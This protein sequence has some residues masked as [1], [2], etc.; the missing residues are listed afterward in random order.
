MT[1]Y[2]SAITPLHA[3]S[4][5]SNLAPLRKDVVSAVLGGR[6]TFFDS[7]VVW[8]VSSLYDITTGCLVHFGGCGIR[9]LSLLQTAS[10][11]HRRSAAVPADCCHHLS[12]L[13]H[14]TIDLFTQRAKECNNQIIDVTSRL[15]Y[16]LPPFVTLIHCGNVKNS[17]LRKCVALQRG[18]IF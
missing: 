16:I 13:V 5:L 1:S 9:L 8:Q 10:A 11:N 14:V 4:G 12:W 17:V 3:L 2:Y 7:G 6:E 15:E 18:R